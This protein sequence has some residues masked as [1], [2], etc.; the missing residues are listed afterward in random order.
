MDHKSRGRARRRS[1]LRDRGK[2]QRHRRS[3]S[4]QGRNKT[5]GNS[6]KVPCPFCRPTLSIRLEKKQTT[7]RYLKQGDF[8]ACS[9]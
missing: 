7:E 6:K 8:V 2:T 9:K 5:I 3:G 4:E 1:K